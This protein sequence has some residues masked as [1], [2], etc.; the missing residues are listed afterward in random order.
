MN[1]T[2]S[3]LVAKSRKRSAS[4]NARRGDWSK[5][6][7]FPRRCASATPCVVRSRGTGLYGEA[8]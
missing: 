3:S 8:F 1:K 4:A 5:R 6:A 7:N 2:D